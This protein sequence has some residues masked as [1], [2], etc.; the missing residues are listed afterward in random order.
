[1]FLQS[2]KNQGLGRRWR[3][4]LVSWVREGLQSESSNYLSCLIASWQGTN[5]S[6]RASQHHMAQNRLWHVLLLAPQELGDYWR[7]DA[8]LWGISGNAWKHEIMG[9]GYVGCHYTDEIQKSHRKTGCINS[10]DQE[11]T[12]FNIARCSLQ[13]RWVMPKAWHWKTENAELQDVPRGWWRTVCPLYK[14][15]VP[16]SA[17]VDLRLLSR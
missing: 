4:Q 14:W 2:S 11:I 15:V 8:G 12:C 10:H 5:L 9:N 6:Q 16:C 1:M 13:K 17:V 7:R 3:P